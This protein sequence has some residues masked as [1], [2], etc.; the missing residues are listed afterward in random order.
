MKTP[1]GPAWLS[2]SH[3][4]A[5]GPPWASHADGG[6]FAARR[7]SWGVLGCVRQSWSAGGAVRGV[8]GYPLVVDQVGPVAFRR[9]VLGI[10]NQE[11]AG[12]GEL[13]GVPPGVDRSLPEDQVHVALFPHAQA[14]SHIHL[15]AYGG[16]LAHRGLGGPLSRGNQVDCVGAAPAGDGVGAFVGFGGQFGVLV[17]DDDQHRIFRRG[18]V[19]STFAFFVA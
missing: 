11:L 9:G 17:G 16:V 7:R 2:A 14:D 13:V 15:R 3:S 6:R 12:L 8:P 4:T 19:H 10:G 5:S 1:S 18:L